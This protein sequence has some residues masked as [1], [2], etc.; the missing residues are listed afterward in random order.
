MRIEHLELS[1]RAYHCLKNEGIHTVEELVE[2]TPQRL[3]HIPNFGRITLGEVEG[4]LN[5]HAL[6]LR[7]STEGVKNRAHRTQRRAAIRALCLLIDST[8]GKTLAQIG[9]KH[10]ISRERAR[11]LVEKGK[12]IKTSFENSMIEKALGC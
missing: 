6:H 11:Q 3:L 12:R 4:A 2:L 1:Y 7:F 10:G 9:E 8:E 5:E